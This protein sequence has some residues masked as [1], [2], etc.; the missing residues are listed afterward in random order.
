M[1]V[2]PGYTKVMTWQAFGADELTPPFKQGD[3]VHINDVKL[4]ERQTGPPDYLTE[5]E[6]ITLM[7]KHGIG[8]DASIPV[9]I[10]NICQRNYVTI[11]TGRK[12]I[13]TTL[14]KVLVHGYL[15]IDP[16]LVLPTMRSDVERLLNLIAQG[17]AEFNSVLKVSSHCMSNHLPTNDNISLS[18]SACHRNISH[19]IPI[20][21]SKHCPN[22]Q[23]L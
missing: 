17:S 20:F 11:A 7:E 21:R 16:E 3:N 9:H 22:G 23:S 5:S 4:V 2:D 15:K 6:L 12:L 10:N 13:P 1:L 8:T 14:G 18:L 19:E